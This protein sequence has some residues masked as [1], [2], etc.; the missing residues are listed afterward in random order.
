MVGNLIR[1]KRSLTLL[2]DGVDSTE[3]AVAGLY[4]SVSLKSV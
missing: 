1:A 3:N 2:V 4:V